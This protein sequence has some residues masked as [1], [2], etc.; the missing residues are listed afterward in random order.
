MGW[1]EQLISY[2][3]YILVDFFWP[4]AG[5]RFHFFSLSLLK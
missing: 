3:I 1:G 5:L 4:K 2:I